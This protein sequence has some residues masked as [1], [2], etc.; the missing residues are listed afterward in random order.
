MKT[1]KMLLL[2]VAVCLLTTTCKKDNSDSTAPSP[3]PYTGAIQQPATP[4]GIA[5]LPQTET[6]TEKLDGPFS[7]LLTGVIANWRIA[8]QKKFEATL[9][10]DC[11]SSSEYTEFNGKTRSELNNKSVTYNSCIPII[12]DKTLKPNFSGEITNY[13]GQYKEGVEQKDVLGM[14]GDY[15]NVTTSG[16]KVRFSRYF[17]VTDLPDAYIR[18]ERRWEIVPVDGDPYFLTYGGDAEL[19]YSKTSGLS[20]E[21]TETWGY[22]LGIEI[23]AGGG[24]APG[25]AAFSATIG[26]EFS[27]TINTWE[28]ETVQKTISQ[29]KPED[30]S[31][32]RIQAFRELLTFTLVNADGSDYAGV[33]CPVIETNVQTIYYV[34]LW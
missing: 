20:V 13:W 18:M 8:S 27:T 17:T 33:Y 2:I 7:P 23:T 25:A 16:H 6:K 29:E 31:A 19:S 10:A 15:Y 11:W 26:Q 5:I 30:I 28:E 3:S 32:M 34:W 14:S 24:F 1:K 4:E 21:E 12:S 22:T 9:Y